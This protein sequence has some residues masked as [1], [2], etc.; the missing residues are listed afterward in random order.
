[1]A[2]LVGLLLLSV[3]LPY[4]D[5]RTHSPHSPSST[6]SVTRR[7]N[8]TRLGLASVDAIKSLEAPP[9]FSDMG[10]FLQLYL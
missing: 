5:V 7:R 2:S 4:I 3:V 9:R 10:D 1:M 6:A 8:T